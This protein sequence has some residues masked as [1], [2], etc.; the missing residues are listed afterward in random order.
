MNCGDKREAG[1][2]R[3]KE[4]FYVQGK[5][6]LISAIEYDKRSA[7]ISRKGQNKEGKENK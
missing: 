3:T 1:G 7:V 4:Y 5:R 6:L 2:H